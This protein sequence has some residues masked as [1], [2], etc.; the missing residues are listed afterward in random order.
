MNGSPCPL[1][2]KTAPECRCASERGPFALYDTSG[3][4][5]GNFTF[6]ELAFTCVRV[7]RKN[8]NGKFKPT[9]TDRHGVPVEI[10]A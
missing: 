6:V 10:P 4:P 8:T 5:C 7:L 9:L 2:K 1:C 3:Y